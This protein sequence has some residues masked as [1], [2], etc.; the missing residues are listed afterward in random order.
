[1]IENINITMLYSNS[2]R[3][4]FTAPQGVKTL[5]TISEITDLDTT[6]KYLER[7][8]IYDSSVKFRDGSPVYH[9]DFPYGAT[10]SAVDSYTPSMVESTERTNTY[11]VYNSYNNE[12][13]DIINLRHTTLYKIVVYSANPFY[14]YD[15]V[16]I[17]EV[18]T[19]FA[20][21][22]EPII[23]EAYDARTRMQ[24]NDCYISFKNS[25]GFI[26]DRTLNTDAFRYT[27]LRIEEGRYDISVVKEGYHSVILKGVFVQREQILNDARQR[28]LTSIAITD[29]GGS[30]TRPELEQ[31][32]THKVYLNP[33]DNPTQSWQKFGSTNRFSKITRF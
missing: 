16:E 23:I 15:I 25:R 28:M 19:G 1:M 31:R 12:N 2:I 27:S 3:I 26:S 20:P 6:V 4:S 5:I 30:F 9:I 33:L 13:V 10:C 29:F 18:T 32:L 22:T 7:G 11:V 21:N 8:V 17:L 24:L 14:C